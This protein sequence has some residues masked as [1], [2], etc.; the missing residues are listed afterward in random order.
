MQIR[1]GRLLC[2]LP[3]TGGGQTEM[4]NP[5]QNRKDIIEEMIRQQLNDPGSIR[6]TDGTTFAYRFTLTPKE[7]VSLGLPPQTPQADILLDLMMEFMQVKGIDEKGSECAQG[8]YPQEAKGKYIRRIFDLYG[9]KVKEEKKRGE[10]GADTEGERSL[11][12]YLK[13]DKMRQ[14][15]RFYLNYPAVDKENRELHLYIET[16]TDEDDPSYINYWVGCEEFTQKH[17]IASCQGNLEQEDLLQVVKVKH[18]Y[19]YLNK[20][21]NQK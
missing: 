3:E 20:I 10:A 21:M 1:S 7:A 14:V 17:Y 16:E 12:L 2:G 5:V 18:L 15:R 11:S 4:E 9:Q 19:A 13:S 8:E 6:M